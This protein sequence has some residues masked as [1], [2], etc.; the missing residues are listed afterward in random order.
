MNGSLRLKQHGGGVNVF[1]AII[2]QQGGQ[3][4]Q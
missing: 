1:A 2:T 4:C 3:G